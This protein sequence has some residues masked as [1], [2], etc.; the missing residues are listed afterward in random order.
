MKEAYDALKMFCIFV[1]MIEILSCTHTKTKEKSEVIVH[2]RE[3]MNL[4]KKGLLFP[5]I[6][7]IQI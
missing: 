2:Q 1:A 4:R 5:Y 7:Q 3:T 6:I